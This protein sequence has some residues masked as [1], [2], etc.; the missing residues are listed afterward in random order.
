MNTK[1]Q[2]R[3]CQGIIPNRI[4]IE[5]K[6]HALMNRKFCLICSPF[7]KHNTSKYDPTER[8]K[9]KTWKQYSEKGKEMVKKCLYK[10]AYKR[11]IEAINSKGG[12]CE[13]CGYKK[14]IRALS[15]HHKN[16][17]EKLFGLS[18]NMFWSKSQDTIEA[19]VQKC[20]LLCLNCHAEREEQISNDS[21]SDLLREIKTDFGIIKKCDVLDLNQ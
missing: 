7:K 4:I 9:G 6:S 1:R 21:C 14:S 10:R 11:K 20:Q 8:M 5:G 12:C 19:E 2:C 13:S 18:L 3:K 16:R 17:E 15:F